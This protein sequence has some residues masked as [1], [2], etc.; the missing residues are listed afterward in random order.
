[1]RGSHPLILV[2]DTESGHARFGNP[3]TPLIQ[4]W[5][6]TMLFGSAFIICG[7][8]L[9]AFHLLAHV[10]GETIGFT[11]GR[12]WNWVRQRRVLEPCLAAGCAL[13]LAGTAGSV[14][15]LFVWAQTGPAV[16]ETRLSIA[17]PSVTLLA[18][19]VQTMFSGF[20]LALIVMQG[21]VVTPA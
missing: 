16:I 5:G 20:L 21:R 2:A 12:L 3:L 6:Y 1:M 10:F 4:N 8:Q 19:G 14:W 18:V 11:D 17:I 15:S 9:A 7:V 13:A